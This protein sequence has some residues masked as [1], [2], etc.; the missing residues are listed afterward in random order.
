MLHVMG[1]RARTWHGPA[2]NKGQAA[3]VSTWMH[4]GHLLEKSTGGVPT[5]NTDLQPSP[6]FRAGVR[7]GSPVQ[8][9]PSASAGCMEAQ[10]ETKAVWFG[11]HFPELGQ[12]F[13]L[14]GWTACEQGV[15]LL[16]ELESFFIWLQ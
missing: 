9:P 10:L 11:L 5:S 3:A 13:R 16:R 12:S 15:L 4:Q 1:P 14:G 8:P 6:G 7:V 2:P